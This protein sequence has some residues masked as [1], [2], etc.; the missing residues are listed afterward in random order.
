[1]VRDREKLSCVLDSAPQ[2][3]VNVA[4]SFRN[5]F[6]NSKNAGL[7]NRWFVFCFCFLILASSVTFRSLSCTCLTS[8]WQ[9]GLAVIECNTI[10][11][12]CTSVNVRLQLHLHAAATLPLSMYICGKVGAIFRAACWVRASAHERL[13]PQR[14]FLPLRWNVLF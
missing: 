13:E 11:R 3:S 6:N 8:T 5:V 2:K 10:H 7:C 4:K 1:M 9:F 12:L 14:G